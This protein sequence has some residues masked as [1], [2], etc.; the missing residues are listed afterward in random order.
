M[1]DTSIPFALRG[2]DPFLDSIGL[3]TSP[4][5]LLVNPVQPA[6]KLRLHQ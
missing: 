1:N 2:A 6:V 4:N 5:N 3:L